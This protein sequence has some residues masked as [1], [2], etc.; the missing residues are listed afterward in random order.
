MVVTSNK[1]LLTLKAVLQ[2]DNF[3]W[4]LTRLHCQSA[5]SH[6]LSDAHRYMLV[7]VPLMLFFCIGRTRSVRFGNVHHT[8]KA[9]A[10]PDPLWRKGMRYMSFIYIYIIHIYVHTHT[11]IHTY[12]LLRHLWCTVFICLQIPVVNCVRILTIYS[13]IDN[14]LLLDYAPTYVLTIPGGGTWERSCECLIINEL[15]HGYPSSWYSLLFPVSPFD[16]IWF[17]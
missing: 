2:H 16:S 14:W 9:K 11:Y 12:R 7:C 13:L 10:Q 17:W 4:R 15:I 6:S 5:Q 8:M 3:V 1:V